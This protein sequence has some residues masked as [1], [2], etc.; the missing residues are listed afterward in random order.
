M[1]RIWLVLAN[2]FRTTVGKRSFWLTT[3]LLPALVL[4]LSLFSQVLASGVAKEVAQPTLTPTKEGTVGVV[5]EAGLIRSLPPELNERFLVLFETEQEAR[6]ALSEGRIGRFCV[7]PEEYLAGGAV[8]VVAPRVRPLDSMGVPASVLY[9]LAFNLTGNATTARL[10][11][12]PLG[13]LKVTSPSGDS[14]DQVKDQSV[15]LVPYA[16]LMLFYFVIIMSSSYMLQSM[17]KEKEGRTAELLLVS[18]RPRELM[19]GKIL[20]LCGVSL[21]QVAV[22][23][24]GGFVL[25]KW[26]RPSLLLLGPLPVLSASFVIWSVAYFSLGFFMFAALLGALGALAP[27]V[28]E[29]NQFVFVAVAPLIVPLLLSEAVIRDPNGGLASFLGL[30][31][32]TSCITM[33]T[34]MAAGGVP[35]WQQVLG[36]LILA[37]TAYGFIRLAGRLVRAD[38]LLGRGAF[39]LRRVVAELGLGIG[40]R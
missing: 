40:K 21:L 8:R 5:D 35:I 36:L 34:R 3:V 1:K 17:T 33:P 29:G 10:L 13:N 27:G 37:L 31:P 7:I 6:L 28:R 2:E 38:T 23:L 22:W 25:L 16:V 12:D 39:D 20:G 11:F 15:F 4:A 18:V 24:G 30:F 9:A 14:L 32:L 26:L 19:M